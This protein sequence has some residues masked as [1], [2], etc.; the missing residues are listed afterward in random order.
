M[1]WDAAPAIAEWL[2]LA[3]VVLEEVRLVDE[4]AADEARSTQ[5]RSAQ[6]EDRLRINS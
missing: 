4:G 5:P 6:N 1:N 2:G 3:L